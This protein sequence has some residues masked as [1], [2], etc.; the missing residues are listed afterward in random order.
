M[1]DVVDKVRKS[2]MTYPT[3]SLNCK[4]TSKLIH[5]LKMDVAAVAKL[6]E[7]SD[8]GMETKSHESIM[9]RRSKCCTLFD[10]HGLFIT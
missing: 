6:V 2:G 3:K 4:F 7:K 1:N 9:R 5:G 10:M 8:R